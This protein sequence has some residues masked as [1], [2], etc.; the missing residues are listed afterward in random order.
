VKGLT[1]V[2]YN[3]EKRNQTEKIFG[4]AKVNRKEQNPLL[5]FNI[6][7]IKV[8]KHLADALLNVF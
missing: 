3:V 2:E 4:V 6:T 7:Q 5:L 1:T 8:E